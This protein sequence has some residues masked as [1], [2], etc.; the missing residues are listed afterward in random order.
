[1]PTT[2]P[3]AEDASWASSS[4]ESQ[5]D[6]VGRLPFKPTPTRKALSSS[7]YVGIVFCLALVI[8]STP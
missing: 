7:E 5:T 3:P 2:S 4:K 6:Q 8:F 1:M